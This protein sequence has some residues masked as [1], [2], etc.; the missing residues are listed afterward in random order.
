MKRIHRPHTVAL[1]AANLLLVALV[2]L[3][4]PAAAQQE[5]LTVSLSEAALNSALAELRD[6][7]STGTAEAL[8]LSFPAVSLRDMEIV[9][10]GTGTRPNGEAFSYEAVIVPTLEQNSLRWTLTGIDR[11]SADGIVSPRDAASGLPTGARYFIDVWEH[12][13]ITA[14]LNSGADFIPAGTTPAALRNRAVE[15]VTISAGMLTIT[16]NADAQTARSDEVTTLDLQDGRSTLVITEQQANDALAAFARRSENVET[17]AVDMTPNGFLLEIHGVLVPNQP[18]GIIAILIGLVISPNG[19]VDVTLTE[20][21]ESSYSPVPRDAV[22]TML[23]L[24]GHFL[25]VQVG[26]RQVT[27]YE[28]TDGA[29]TLTLG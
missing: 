25:A 14:L 12:A 16:F 27:G 3:A 24:W 2:L 17:F 22:S 29:L 1:L 28:L 5:E 21:T 8:P 23:N 9:L 19:T 6:S 7:A 15:A 18:Q 11:I 10:F 4:V 20:V 13:Y 26:D